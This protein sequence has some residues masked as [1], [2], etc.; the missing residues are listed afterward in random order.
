MRAQVLAAGPGVSMP[1][2]VTGE[3]VPVQDTARLKRTLIA[4]LTWG[5]TAVLVATTGSRAALWPLLC[6]PTLV[7][8]LLLYAPGALI[9]GSMNAVLVFLSSHEAA[10]TA[11]VGLVAFTLAGVL[12]GVHARQARDLQSALASAVATDPATGACTQAHFEARV[13]EEIRRC[14][15]YGCTCG[16]VRVSLDGFD[17]FVDKF[18]TRRAAAALA[19]LAEVVRVSV[20]ETDSIGR[21]DRHDLGILMPFQSAEGCEA[22]A[23]RVAGSVS[24]TAFEGDSVEPCVS[25]KATAVWAV[26]PE[27]A[28]NVRDLADLLAARLESAR[29]EAER[30]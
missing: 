4:T 7:A 15:R 19:R 21:F 23:R 2:V 9:A 17:A 3:L 29:G 22:L 6:I 10:S 13:A 25:L 5:F 18:G 28:D 27:E 12:A 24:R 14:V 11:W 26:V 20:R 8:G 30:A 16:V 1:G